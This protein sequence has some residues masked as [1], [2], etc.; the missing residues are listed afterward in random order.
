MCDDLAHAVEPHG[1]LIRRVS[2]PAA[3]E[4]AVAHDIVCVRERGA[5]SAR[6][7]D[8]EGTDVLE[9]ALSHFA[10]GALDLNRSGAGVSKVTPD[11][12]QAFRALSPDRPGRGPPESEPF[13][14]HIRGLLDVEHRIVQQR[15]TKLRLARRLIFRRPEIRP[16]GVDVDPVFAGASVPP[17]CSRSGTARPCPS[18]TCAAGPARSFRPRRRS[19]PPASGRR[20][21]P[22]CQYPR[23]QTSLA[24][25]GMRARR[26]RSFTRNVPARRGTL[27]ASLSLDVPGS[28]MPAIPAQLS[29]GHRADR[30]A[31]GDS[32]RAR[33]RRPAADSCRGGPGRR[34][35]HHR[36][37]QCR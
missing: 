28:T 32:C 19:C 20:P 9:R 24:A 6:E 34:V 30:G 37:V 1:G 17:G 7:R 16:R 15:T 8:T 3:S 35:R 18:H 4:G 22:Q 2:S 12:P 27:G 5:I 26:S 25:A 31:D 11:D 23:S 29:L 14:L 21:S 33:C 36:F 10:L 13:D